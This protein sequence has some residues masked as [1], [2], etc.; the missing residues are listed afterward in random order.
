MTRELIRRVIRDDETTHLTTLQKVATSLGGST[1]DIDTC[2]F[3]FDTALTDVKTFL[4]TARVLEI[5]GVGA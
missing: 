1:G 5:I 2:Q 4:G 3:N